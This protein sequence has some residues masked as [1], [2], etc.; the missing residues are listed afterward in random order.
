MAGL[1]RTDAAAAWLLLTLEG[2]AGG[3]A[4]LGL[5]AFG[6]KSPVRSVYWS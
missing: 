5:G 4:T 3:S 6:I 1:A 2:A